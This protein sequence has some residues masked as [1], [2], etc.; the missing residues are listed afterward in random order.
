MRESGENSSCV[1]SLMA[2]PILPTW[3]LYLSRLCMHPQSRSRQGRPR[4]SLGSGAA[5]SGRL[6]D[7]TEAG[8]R[9]RVSV[10]RRLVMDLLL[11]PGA[12]RGAEAGIG[13]SEEACDGVA[14]SPSV[15]EEGLGGEVQ[16]KRG[17]PEGLVLI[18]LLTALT[19]EEHP[20]TC[21]SRG[22]CCARALHDL[23]D[24]LAAAV[25]GK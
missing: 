22:D 6:D 18:A 20:A 2:H 12:C 23:K 15:L 16:A 10:C 19:V 25:H 5:W 9:V 13:S 17:R 21:C 3:E 14:R 7:R 8:G 11:L 24:L 4:F 1:Q